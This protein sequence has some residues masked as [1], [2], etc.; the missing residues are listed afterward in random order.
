ML[1]R[2]NSEGESSTGPIASDAGVEPISLGC[3]KAA[4]VLTGAER[5]CGNEEQQESHGRPPA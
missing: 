3:L 1:P 2:W 5:R 4:G